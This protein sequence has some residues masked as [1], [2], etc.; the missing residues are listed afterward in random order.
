MSRPTGKSKTAGTQAA[1]D[2][3]K[4]ATKRSRTD[5]NKPSQP[6][7]KTRCE[8]RG[9]LERTEA[10][11]EERLLKKLEKRFMESQAS[12]P[13]AQ[14]LMTPSSKMLAGKALI[15]QASKLRAYFVTAVWRVVLVGRL[16]PPAPTQ[17]PFCL[18]CCVFDAE[19]A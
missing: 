15:M 16:V 2:A 13:S 14:V 9:A 6:F 19:T 3:D 7:K 12:K 17:C 10:K 5:S 11:M 18:A 4:R 8:D 1:A